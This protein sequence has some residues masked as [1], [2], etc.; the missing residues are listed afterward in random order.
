MRIDHDYA[1][2]VTWIGNLGTGT[3]GY[4]AY[5][6]DTV[7]D[8]PGHPQ[9]A[10]SSDRAFRGS[11][12]RWNPEEL[13]VAALSECHLLSYLH[14]AADNGIVVTAYRDSATG[15][16]RQAPDGGGAFVEVTLNP[17]VTISGGDAGLA[18]AL[19]AR[20]GELCFIAR[21]VN[22]PVHH[23]PTTLVA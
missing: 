2:S 19:H 18:T 7:I 15:V 11:A 17:V 21:S 3:S 23:R 13:L 9:L 22:F 16:M 14:V 5:G 20:A 8:A 12:D 10:A 1:V 6:R 4:R